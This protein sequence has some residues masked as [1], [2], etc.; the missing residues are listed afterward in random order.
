M[1]EEIVVENAQ[2]RLYLVPTPIGNLEDITVRAL[3]IL[4]DVELI[5]AEDT[6]VT[7]KLLAHYEINTPMIS[8]HEHNETQR[9]PHIMNVLTRSDVALVSDA[10]MPGLSDPGDALIKEAIDQ[11]VTVSALPGASAITSALPM[12]GLP[13]DQFTYVGF[14]PRRASQRRGALQK[15]KD[16]DTTLVV[17]ETPHR[18]RDMLEDLLLVLG[19]RKIAV[20]REISKMYEETFRGTIED[21]L[22]HFLKPR[23]EFTL[24][25]EGA[26]PPDPVDG[27]IEEYIGDLTAAALSPSEAV[28][29]AMRR[30]NVTRKRAYQIFLG[31]REN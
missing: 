27:E 14:L 13:I 24:I 30:F 28:Q 18:I 2:G 25:I 5:G 9:T 3:R 12:S 17:F 4:G 20:C 26:D 29:K 31:G 15:L 19:N 8:Y 11:G 23:G 21:A 6:R 1:N 22:A 10:G 7:K 16:Q